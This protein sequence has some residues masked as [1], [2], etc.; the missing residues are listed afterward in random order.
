MKCVNGGAPVNEYTLTI[1]I[2]CFCNL[3]RA[4]LGFSILGSFFK[5]GYNPSVTTFTT[6]LKGL[7]LE[8][9]V[10]EGEKLFKKLFREKYC[11]PNEVTIVTVMDGLCKARETRKAYR[12]L[13]LWEKKGYKP[14]VGCYNTLINRLCKDGKFDAACKLVSIMIGKGVLPDV[15]TYSSMI[16]GLCDFGRWKEAKDLLNEMQAEKV[17]P[18]LRTCNIFLHG[19]RKSGQIDEAFPFYP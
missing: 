15:I 13:W 14:Y 18:S 4:D 1:L 17:T 16:Q 19:L 10:S 11:E 8:E 6:L 3:N 9:K 7:F 2:N 12:L 5:C